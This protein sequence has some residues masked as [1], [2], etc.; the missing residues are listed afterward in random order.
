MNGIVTADLSEFGARELDEAADLLKAYTNSSLSV[1]GLSIQ[2]NKHSGYVFLSNDEY[3][4]WMINSV[5]DN[6]DE[7]IHC[8]NCG[9]EEFGSDWIPARSREDIIEDC[10]CDNVEEPDDWELCECGAFEDYNEDEDE[11]NENKMICPHCRKG[12]E[13][14]EQV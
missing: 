9:Y 8:S 12:R 11:D 2:F 10:T 1:S 4:T 14:Y 5:T 13:Y 7:F 6:L 3:R